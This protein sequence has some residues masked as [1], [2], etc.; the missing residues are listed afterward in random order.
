MVSSWPNVSLLRI[1]MFVCSLLNGTTCRCDTMGIFALASHYGVV[2]FKSAS[3]WTNTTQL[4]ANKLLRS[5]FSWNS[6]IVHKLMPE[7][8]CFK[9][10]TPPPLVAPSSC[11]LSHVFSGWTEMTQDYR[12]QKSFWWIDGLWWQLSRATRSSQHPR[13]LMIFSRLKPLLSGLRGRHG[14]LSNWWLNLGG[15]SKDQFPRSRWWCWI[16]KHS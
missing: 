10:G 9:P 1:R 7:S 15:I 4:R 8:G 6:E 5:S 14:W 13:V 2:R 11:D 16:L 12:P 3:L